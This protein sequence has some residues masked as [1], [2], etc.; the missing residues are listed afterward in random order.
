[1]G[2]IQSE[3]GSLNLDESSWRCLLYMRVEMARK[4][5]EIYGVESRGGIT[6]VSPF[7]HIRS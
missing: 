5:L 7:C 4:Q 2:S 1:M 3:L 6:S